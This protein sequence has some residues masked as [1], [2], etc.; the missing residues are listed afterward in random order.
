M[1]LPTLVQAKAY[2]KKQTADE[3]TLIGDLLTRSKAK[4]R[5][6]LGRQIDIV[7]RT[8]TDHAVNGRAYGSLTALR[9]PPQYLPCVR[10]DD[11]SLSAPVV[12]DT[13]GTVLSDSVDYYAGNPWDPMLRSRVGVAFSNGPYSVTVECG[14]A[15]SPDY[16]NVIEPDLSAAILDVL[17]DLYQRRSPAAT[18]ESTGGGVSTS[19]APNGLPLRAWESIRQWAVVRIV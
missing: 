15:A 17:A 18:N 13:D 8:F 16:A 5:G 14:L 7:A 19:Y 9:I 10:V 2:L 4:V 1:A 3:D 11:S 12:T 6:A